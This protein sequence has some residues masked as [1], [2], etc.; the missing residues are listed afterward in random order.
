MN[1]EMVN[2][3]NEEMFSALIFH[4]DSMG[5]RLNERMDQLENSLSTRMDKLEARMDKLE[6]RMDKLEARMDSLEARVDSLEARMDSLEGCVM[7]LKS[8]T[9]IE[10][11]AVRVEMDMVYRSLNEN[12]AALNS[13]IDRL[14]V[15]WNVDGL[16]IAK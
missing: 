3:T 6:V 11:K 1:K 10:F 12:T 8:D 2:M 13:K 4:M 5:A 14:L 16:A 15:T 9:A 7:H